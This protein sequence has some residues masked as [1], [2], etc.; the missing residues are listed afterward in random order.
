MSRPWTQTLTA[1]SRWRGRSG[2]LGL[3]AQTPTPRHKAKTTLIRNREFPLQKRSGSEKAQFPQCLVSLLTERF[4]Q[5]GFA[6][7]PNN[8]LTPK[9]GAGGG[10]GETVDERNAGAVSSR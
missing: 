8:P 4:F 10:A 2:K 1:Q 9:Y 3:T 5:I 7:Y 6:A